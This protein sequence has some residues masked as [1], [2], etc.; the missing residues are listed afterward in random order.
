MLMK[1]KALEYKTE[2]RLNWRK[3]SLLDPIKPTQPLNRDVNPIR[4]VS[5]HLPQGPFLPS[6]FSVIC[7]IFTP[8]LMP[9]TP[10]RRWCKAMINTGGKS[11]LHRA[12]GLDET[13][14][15]TLS[16]PKKLTYSSNPVKSFPEKPLNPHSIFSIFHS[17]LSLFTCLFSIKVGYSY[18]RA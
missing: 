16:Q 15:L 3:R 8:Y 5:F 13:S 6:L 11:Q 1:Y 18:H 7:F 17:C 9:L 10:I 4:R 12:T 14:G 2:T